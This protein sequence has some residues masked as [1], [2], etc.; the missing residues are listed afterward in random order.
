MVA[1]SLFQGVFTLHP[2]KTAP[3]Y[4]QYGVRPY[5]TKPEAADDDGGD[6]DDDSDNR[7]SD[8]DDDEDDG[9]MITKPED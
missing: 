8:D 3:D 6:D 9:G 2:R 1:S 7:G 4:R 5:N